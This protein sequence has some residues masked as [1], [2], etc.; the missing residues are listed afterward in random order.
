M[1]MWLTSVPSSVS[2]SRWPWSAKIPQ[3]FDW[4]AMAEERGPRVTHMRSALH[5]MVQATVKSCGRP[6]RTEECFPFGLSAEA[7]QRLHATVA[8]H[9]EAVGPAI[10]AGVEGVLASHG[11]LDK[12]DAV[13]AYLRD[14]PRSV[15]VAQAAATPQVAI[16]A[17]L[18]PVRAEAHASLSAQVETLESEVRQM[19]SE[20]AR[21]AAALSER[22]ARLADAR[23]LYDSALWHVLD[24]APTADLET[25]VD[26]MAN[27][28]V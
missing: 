9:L 11:A 4:R 10:E 24:A 18:D 7:L 14:A 28:P 26:R 17:A 6:D 19:R 22:S 13:D 15:S 21:R 20:A 8:A 16:S 27:E 3:F 23:R 2:R 5:K 12:L 25:L 1:Q